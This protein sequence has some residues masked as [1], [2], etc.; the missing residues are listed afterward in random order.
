MAERVCLIEGSVNTLMKQ[1][2]GKALSS[3]VS[4]HLKSLDTTLKQS[5]QLI[6]SNV[7]PAGLS[8][9]KRK[10]FMAKAFAKRKEIAAQFE[11]QAGAISTSLSGLGLSMQARV[12]LAASFSPNCI[13]AG[14]DCG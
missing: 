9:T 10:V 2:A 11:K 4:A 3:D 14:V 1:Q 8:W 7:C 12:C 6:T 5:Q 13:F